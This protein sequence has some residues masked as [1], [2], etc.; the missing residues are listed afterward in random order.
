MEGG[1]I[2]THG[3]DTSAQ[4][5]DPH[6]VK[7]VTVYFLSH[8]ILAKIY[9]TDTIESFY[10]RVSPFLFQISDPM[11]CSSGSLFPISALQTKSGWVTC[12]FCRPRTFIR[13]WNSSKKTWWSHTIK[14][15]NSVRWSSNLTWG[16]S[17]RWLPARNASRTSSRFLFKKPI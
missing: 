4:P 11:A 10:D 16:E 15:S 6:M 1:S 17:S 7:L 14:W 8:R 9:D 13:I 3:Q 2:N 12:F 5:E